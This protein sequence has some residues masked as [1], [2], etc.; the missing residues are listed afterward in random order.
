MYTINRVVI[1]TRKE[2]AAAVAHAM[3]LEALMPATHWLAALTTKLLRMNTAA[4]T[5]IRTMQSPIIEVRKSARETERMEDIDF[6]SGAI[7]FLTLFNFFQG[8]EGHRC[9]KEYNVLL[10]I[11]Q[12]WFSATTHFLHES[13][14]IELR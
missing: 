3:T 1:A 5:M 6:I 2:A 8:N 10:K 7:L 14:F 9:G 13:R 11:S 4:A 12:L